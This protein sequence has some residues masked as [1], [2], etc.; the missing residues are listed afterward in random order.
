M[1]EPWPPAPTVLSHNAQSPVLLQASKQMFWAIRT[2]V[3]NLHPIPSFAQLCFK[4]S[5]HHTA[6]LLTCCLQVTAAEEHLPGLPAAIQAALA[7]SWR[8]PR[9]GYLCHPICTWWQLRNTCL[10][11]LWPPR[12]RCPE[13]LEKPG[14]RCRSAIPG[15]VWR[16]RWITLS[17]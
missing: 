11:H 15:Y 1:G 3:N 12:P 14:S 7:G 9:L 16:Q 17:R 4:P 10:G 5:S 2:L 13:A 8:T 6:A